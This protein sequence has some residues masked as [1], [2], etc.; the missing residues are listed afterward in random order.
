MATAAPPS[1]PRFDSEPPL[2]LAPANE[3]EVTIPA[4]VKQW[5]IDFKSLQIKAQLGRGSFG[6]VRLAKWNGV[7][8]AVKILHDTQ[9]ASTFFKGNTADASH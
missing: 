5:R 4:L 1:L 3:V 6:E 7:D 8:V 2:V 9:S